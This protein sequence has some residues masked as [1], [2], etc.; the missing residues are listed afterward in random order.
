MTQHPS[1]TWPIARKQARPRNRSNEG[2][3]GRCPETRQGA[4]PP[5]PPPEAEPLDSIHFGWGEGGGTGLAWVAAITPADCRCDGGDPGQPSPPAL[6]PTNGRVPRAPP[7]AG[8]QGA[9]PLGGVRGKAPPFSRFERLHA[10]ACLRVTGPSARRRG[11]RDCDT[12]TP[13]G[14]AQYNGRT[15]AKD[16][17]V[18]AGHATQPPGASERGARR[19]P[20]LR[21]IE[22]P[23]S[24]LQPLRPLRRPRGCCGRQD[25]EGR[26]SR[27]TP[28]RGARASLV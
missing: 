25:A 11:S 15:Q 2:R 6:T 24:C 5:G 8:I 21:R 19:V 27:L 17:A 12:V 18:K 16:L 1:V 20:E 9:A 14:G 13:T 3:S 7:L 22:A 26:D 28:G 10:V 23:A 4:L